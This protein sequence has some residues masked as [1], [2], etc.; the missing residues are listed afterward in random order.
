MTRADVLAAWF[1]AIA[2]Q[3]LTASWSD[4]EAAVSPAFTTE[5]LGHLCE[6]AQDILSDTRSALERRFKSQGYAVSMFG[7]DVE[8]RTRLPWFVAKPSW[9]PDGVPFLFWCIEDEP[10]EWGDDWYC[11]ATDAFASGPVLDI[12]GDDL[13]VVFM[14]TRDIVIVTTSKRVEPRE[15]RSRR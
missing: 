15:L 3:S 6:L 5:S 4:R 8:M 13:S 10:S 9:S 1:N 14:G 2:E 7:R 11:D 12:V